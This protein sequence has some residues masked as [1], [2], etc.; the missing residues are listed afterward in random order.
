MDQSANQ[1]QMVQAYGGSDRAA[2]SFNRMQY[3]RFGNVHG[4]KDLGVFS[5][6][7]LLVR[8]D[9]GAESGTQTLFFHFSLEE[10]ARI[11]LD[12]HEVTP[13]TGQYLQYA[14]RRVDGPWL[15]ISE[16][17][18]ATWEEGSTTTFIEEVGRTDGSP[19][20]NRYVELDPATSLFYW[21]VGYAEGD[22]GS[23]PS[24]SQVVRV[25]R[26]EIEIAYPIASAVEPGN[27]LLTVSCSQWPQ[28]PFLFRLLVRPAA[29]L[30]GEATVEL[31][32]TARTS[33]VKLG[34]TADV[35]LDAEGRIAKVYNL[36]GEA[37]VTLT[38]RLSVQ[39]TSPF[40]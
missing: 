2:P 26:N 13:R 27:Y 1:L 18:I 39:V 29:V 33:L 21:D 35:D 16:Y 32:P 14:L 9:V 8:G 15:D 3:V 36:A 31:E 20:G 10:T 6:A 19:E 25:V 4:P 23:P 28:I 34:G 38:P 11:G 37:D 24:V 7:D 30:A 22:D 17:G 12:T 40:S 5:S